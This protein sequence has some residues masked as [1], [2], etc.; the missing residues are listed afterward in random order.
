[1]SKQLRQDVRLSDME[2]STSPCWKVVSLS[3]SLSLLR[4]GRERENRGRKGG[5]KGRCWKCTLYIEELYNDGTP[6]EWSMQAL[7]GG[8]Q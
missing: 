2:P 5:R 4:G 8:E 6:E 7:C 3:L 1:M